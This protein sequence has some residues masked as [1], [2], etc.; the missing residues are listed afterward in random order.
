MTDPNQL[1]LNEMESQRNQALNMQARVGAQ[2]MAAMERVAQLEEQVKALGGDPT[3]VPEP[4]AQP[5]EDL[6]EPDLAEDN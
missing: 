5:E 1:L 3:V 6:D 4:K 2:A